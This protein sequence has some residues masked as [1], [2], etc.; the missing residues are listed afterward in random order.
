MWPGMPKFPKVTNLLFLCNILRQKWVIKLIF[1]KQ[2]NIKVDFDTL[3]IKVSCKVILSLLMGMIKHSQITQSNK[4]AIYLQYLK[5]NLGMEVIFCMQINIKVSTSWH[6][7][8]W[9]KWPDMS[10]VFKI[11]SWYYFCNMI[12][13]NCFCFLL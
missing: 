3:D 2:T 4:F 6:Y 8:F 12:R 1:C 13:K 5:K 9:W 7:Q 11:G 10:K